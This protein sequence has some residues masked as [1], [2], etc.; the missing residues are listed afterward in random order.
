MATTSYSTDGQPVPAASTFPT[1]EADAVA[2][3][4]IGAQNATTRNEGPF[5]ALRRPLRPISAQPSPADAPPPN[6]HLLLIGGLVVA[7]GLIW[8]AVS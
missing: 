7:A 8:W 1:M 2:R 4:G 3:G 5:D 6:N